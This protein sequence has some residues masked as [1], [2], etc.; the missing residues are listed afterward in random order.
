MPCLPIRSVVLSGRNIPIHRGRLENVTMIEGS[1]GIWRARIWDGRCPVMWPAQW[2]IT[3][4]LV[5]VTAVLPDI[6]RVKKSINNYLRLEFLSF[7]YK[8]KNYLQLSNFLQVRN[9][10]LACNFFASKMSF[11]IYWLLGIYLQHILL[12]LDIR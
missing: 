11:N 1:P 2:K 4:C 5:Q 10:F 3:P 12:N 7:A 6:I 9:S 8:C